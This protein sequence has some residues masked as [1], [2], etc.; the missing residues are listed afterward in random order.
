MGGNEQIAFDPAACIYTDLVSVQNT[1]EIVCCLALV[2]RFECAEGAFMFMCHSAMSS[3]SFY[4]PLGSHLPRELDI[5]TYCFSS[6]LEP[7]VP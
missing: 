1:S 4:H 5:R 2:L 7:I 3:P 6:I